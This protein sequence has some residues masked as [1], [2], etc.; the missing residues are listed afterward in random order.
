MADTSFDIIME[1]SAAYQA[2][3]HHTEDHAEAINAFFEK[4]QGNYKGK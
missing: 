4:R 2:L 3:A 1:M